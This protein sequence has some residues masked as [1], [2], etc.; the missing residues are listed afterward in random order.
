M[1]YY[2]SKIFKSN[3]DFHE[4]QDLIQNLYEASEQKDET[5]KL[6]LQKAIDSKNARNTMNY[7][8]KLTE[9]TLNLQKEISKQNKRLQ[10]RM[11]I[12]TF[13]LALWAIFEIIS[14]FSK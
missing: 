1:Q 6:C 2:N 4:E 5:L 3:W 7:S 11:I 8:W 9:A 12:L 13:I 10:V 14:F